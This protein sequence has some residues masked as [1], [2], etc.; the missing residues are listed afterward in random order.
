MSIV[1][2]M[3]WWP[4]VRFADRWTRHVTVEPG[5]SPSR[6]LATSGGQGSL[7]SVS[8]AASRAP[9]TTI[10]ATARPIAPARRPIANRAREPAE[11]VPEPILEAILDDDVGIRIM[12]PA[13]SWWRS[14]PRTPRETW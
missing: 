13:P 14:W 2:A 10:A 1:P 6:A 3:V 8:A 9:A 4:I 12:R 5:G 11:L 7:L